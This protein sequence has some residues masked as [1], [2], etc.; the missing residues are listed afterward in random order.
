MIDE[1]VGYVINI[2]DIITNIL[3]IVESLLVLASI[4]ISIKIE[5]AFNRKI[6]WSSLLSRSG[7][8][9]LCVAVLCSIYRHSLIG[10]WFRIIR[11]LTLARVFLEIF[12]Y[13]DILTVIFVNI[14]FDLNYILQF[15][16]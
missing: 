15:M 14:F 7:I 9:D 13:I 2:L 12:P 8:P 16:V 3:F 10:G 5:Q 1:E 4:P 11:V 6:V